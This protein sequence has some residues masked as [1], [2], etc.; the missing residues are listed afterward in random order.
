M[1]PVW[2]FLSSGA[3]GYSGVYGGHVGGR[4]SKNQGPLLVKLAQ[5][6]SK[7]QESTEL[8]VFHR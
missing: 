4:M 1:N 7:Y 6:D 8:K 2:I 5:K 3:K